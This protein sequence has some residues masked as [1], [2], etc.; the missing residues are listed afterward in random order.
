MDT[1]SPPP[2]SGPL[3]IQTVLPPDAVKT[4]DTMIDYCA[5][6]LDRTVACFVE[7]YEN[8]LKPTRKHP[9]ITE[10]ELRDAIAQQA[11]MFGFN[12]LVC[13]LDEWAQIGV[14]PEDFDKIVNHYIEE[15]SSY[16]EH[17]IRSATIPIA[18]PEGVIA[19]TVREFLPDYTAARRLYN[20]LKFVALRSGASIRLPHRAVESISR[21]IDYYKREM[22]VTIGDA[23]QRRE[24]GEITEEEYERQALARMKSFGRSVLDCTLRECA[25][26]GLPTEESDEIVNQ[27]I[28]E[29]SR[30]PEQLY[31]IWEP[32]SSR[33]PEGAIAEAI[34]E[35]L[36]DLVARWR[37]NRSRFFSV[38]SGA[39]TRPAIEESVRQEQAVRGRRFPRAHGTYLK[40]LRN[41][42]GLSQQALVEKV[43]SQA[44]SEA[45]FNIRSY[46]RYEKSE[47][48]DPQNLKALAKVFS[49]ELKRD[50][51]FHDLTLLSSR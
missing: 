46:K 50:I 29:L 35:F 48:A 12:V 31:R 42:A 11:R 24:R 28:E 47:P 9:Q 45:S 27:Q 39:S 10:E 36:S 21:M 40:D 17:R 8:R 26:F 1:S 44:G 5:L 19:G 38:S 16:A 30:Y 43:R 34:R 25:K 3:N 37:I 23:V 14:A 22:N 18:I 41:T 13:A 2:K 51:S 49:E 6:E 4:I 20:H 7:C 32:L 33:F 15:L